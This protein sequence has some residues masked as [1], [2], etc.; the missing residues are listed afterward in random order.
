MPHKV[1]LIN[2]PGIDG[3]FAIALALNDPQLEVVLAPEGGVRQV[4]QHLH[5]HRL[6]VPR[7][8]LLVDYQAGF[9]VAE[10]ERLRAMTMVT[11]VY[12]SA[13]TGR[14]VRV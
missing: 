6:R 9:L 12:E 10:I 2:D 8:G 11:G 7:N 1:V 3:A 13:R 14:L 4:D 5:Q